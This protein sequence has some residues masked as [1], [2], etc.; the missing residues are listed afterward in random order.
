MKMTPT[1]QNVLTKIEMVLTG[2]PA[3]PLAPEPAA[4]PAAAN[5][6]IRFAPPRPLTPEEEELLAERT[7]ALQKLRDEIGDCQRCKLGKGRNQIVFGAGTPLARV[8]FVGEAPGAEEDK[9]GIPFVGRAGQKLTQLIMSIGLSREEVYIAN[10]CKCRPPENR[11]PEADEMA[12]CEKFLIRQLAI[13]KPK[14]ICAMGNTAIQSLLRVKEG[15]S[16]LRGQLFRYENIPVMA[17][18]HPSFLIRPGGQAHE[19]KVLRDFQQLKELIDAPD[20]DD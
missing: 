11:R 8:V 19:G 13:I 18:F 16:K 9:Q 10:I 14:I 2:D 5:P 7:A 3:L 1:Y 20:G 6:S 4:A 12:T 15:I 17:T